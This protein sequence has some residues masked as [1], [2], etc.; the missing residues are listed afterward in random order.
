MLLR[1]F[2]PPAVKVRGKDLATVL[3]PAYDQLATAPEA[4]AAS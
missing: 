4:E 2:E 1:M 3:A